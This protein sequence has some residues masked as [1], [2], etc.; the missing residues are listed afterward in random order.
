MQNPRLAT[1]Y[2][3]SILDLAIERDSLDAVLKDMQAINRICQ[4]S[5][6]FEVMLRSPVISG[7]KKLTVIYMVLKNY[8]INILTKGFIDLLVNKSRE[9]NL[10][11]IAAAFVTQY[12]TLKNIRLVKLTTASPMNDAIKST[13]VAKIASYMPNDTIELTTEVDESLIGGFVLETDDKLYD[14]SIKKSLNDVRSKVV[15]TSYVN[16]M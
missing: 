8:D 11:E 7:D 15:D 2:A 14:A 16:K 4:A 6:D 10:P 1:R 12:N 13:V 3:K 9:L 5:H